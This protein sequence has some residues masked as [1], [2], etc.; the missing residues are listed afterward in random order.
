MA[1]QLDPAGQMTGSS[2]QAGAHQSA[3]SSL[4]PP[5]CP[6]H[7]LRLGR[8][9]RPEKM[10]A[11]GRAPA[12]GSHYPRTARGTGEAACAAPVTVRGCGAHAPL[13]AGASSPHA[14]LRLAAPRRAAPGAGHSPARADSS[15]SRRLQQPSAAGGGQAEAADPRAHAPLQPT[16][17]ERAV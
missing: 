11:L 6:P 5:R 7:R 9:G 2:S 3:G 16:A 10:P 14:S 8:L 13:N 4:W 17:A 1:H 12:T 15:V